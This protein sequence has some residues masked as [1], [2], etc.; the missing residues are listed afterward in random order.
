MKQELRLETKQIITP[1]FLLNLK[2]LALP[3]I[4]LQ[5]LIRNELEQNPALEIIVEDTEE[6]EKE[7]E[8]TEIKKTKMN[9]I[10]L[11]LL[12]MIFIV[13]L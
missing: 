12:G 2:L 5:T 3:N 7:L 8:V 13:Y 1:Q 9:L 10:L 6:P 4:E 11:T